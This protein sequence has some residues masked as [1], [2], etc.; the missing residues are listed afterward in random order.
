MK[1]LKVFGDIGNNDITTTDDCDITTDGDNVDDD[2]DG[3]KSTLRI[4]VVVILPS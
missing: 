3:Y 2:D 4:C 1:K